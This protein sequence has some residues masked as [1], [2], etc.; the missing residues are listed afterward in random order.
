MA[1]WKEE[2]MAFQVSRGSARG[3]FSWK[4]PGEWQVTD[5]VFARLH[6]A[7]L[8]LFLLAPSWCPPA[9]TA[10][11]PDAFPAHCPLVPSLPGVS[12]SAWHSRD[13]TVT[14]LLPPWSR[15]IRCWSFLFFDFLWSFL[16][17]NLPRCIPWVKFINLISP[18][19]M[20][21][22]TKSLCFQSSKYQKCNIR[23]TKV[24]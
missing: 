5:S 6:C 4:N 16:L 7:L 8:Q 24:G 23:L 3:G 20:Y 14:A 17:H 9:P 21:T 10:P 1:S 18:T 2:V 13:T 15:P 22:V 11:S 12:R 19:W